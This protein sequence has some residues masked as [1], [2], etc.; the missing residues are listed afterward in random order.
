MGPLNDHYTDTGNERSSPQCLS[1]PEPS[2]S[3]TF[4]NLIFQVITEVHY[5]YPHCYE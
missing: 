3:H 5:Q 4:L 2:T 1:G